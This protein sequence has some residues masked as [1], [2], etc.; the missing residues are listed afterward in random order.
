MEGAKPTRA[1]RQVDQAWL[2]RGLVIGI[3]LL[4]A[5]VALV[6]SNDG[7]EDGAAPVEGAARV[8]DEAGLREAAATLG[9]PIYWTGPVEGTELEL[10]EL[11]EGG[12]QVR[13]A[14]EGE[15]GE[16][17]S[18]VLTIGTYPLPDPAAALE[19]FAAKPG[20][21]VREGAS[22]TKVY[23]SE[24]APNSVYF[25]DPEGG[26]QVE[27]YAPAASEAMSLALSGKVE[28]VE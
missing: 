10:E 16:A 22:G 27:V 9:R 17:R 19:R 12:V 11:G 26:V 28:R 2:L 21:I 25:G 3:A 4:I 1:G 24:E 18:D 5:V 14:P 13:Y 15:G 20:A 23:S 6:V 8:V 7:D